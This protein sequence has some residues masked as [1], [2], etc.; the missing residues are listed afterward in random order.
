[1]EDELLSFFMV[2]A[3]VASESQAVVGAFVAVGRVVEYE[4][5]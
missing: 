3:G 1:M 5:H 4:Q 2:C